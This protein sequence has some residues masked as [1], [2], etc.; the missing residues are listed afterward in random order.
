MA[1]AEFVLLPLKLLS[2]QPLN[3]LLSFLAC[4][5]FNFD[6][7]I[8]SFEVL[9]SKS[10]I[11]ILRLLPRPPLFNK[12][13]FMEI[14]DFVLEGVADYSAAF[15]VDELSS[16]IGLNGQICGLFLGSQLLLLNRIILITALGVVLLNLI[17]VTESLRRRVL[18][19]R[20]KR[21]GPAHP[22][23]RIIGLANATLR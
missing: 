4:Q 18:T 6:R 23:H 7:A 15:F 12:F 20:R 2:L 3:L 13:L 17:K 21:I 19:M 16:N 11:F 1:S 10:S 22:L 5:L 8:F 14:F 9:F